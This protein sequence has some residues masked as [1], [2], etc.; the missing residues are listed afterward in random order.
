MSRVSIFVACLVLG[1]LA[2]SGVGQE[3]N[4]LPNGDFEK[5]SDGDGVPDG[6]VGNPHHFSRETLEGVHAYIKAFPSHAELLKGKE[7]RYSDSHLYIRREADKEWPDSVK[8]AS[9]YEGF[10]DPDN[11]LWASRLGS[12]PLPQGLE[13]GGVTLVGTLAPRVVSEPIAVKPNTGYRLSYWSRTCG[14]LSYAFQVLDAEANLSEEYPGSPAGAQMV[15]SLSLGWAYVPYWTRYE[16]PFR[17]GPEQKAIRIRPWLYI[18][19]ES[20]YH[21]IYFDDFRLVEDDSVVMGDISDP[22]N[23]EPVWPAEAVERG[24]AVAPRPTLPQTFDT[25][26]PLPEEIDQ[27]MVVT[28][29]PG[30]FASGV[31][32]LRALR[33]LGGPLVVG[34]KGDGCSHLNGWGFLS[35]YGDV[36]LRVC[37][38]LKVDKNGSQWEMRP[39]YL[40]PG[41]LLPEPEKISVTLRGARAVKVE[42]PKG[43]GRSVWVTAFVPA[44]APPGDYKGEIQVVASGSE[45]YA[46]PFTI[47]VRDLDLL[48]PDVDF[49]MYRSTYA[50]APDHVVVPG[51]PR[52]ALADN[53]RHGMTSVDQGGGPVWVYEDADGRT[54][55]NWS[56]FDV[57]M[58]QMVSAGFRKSFHYMPDGDAL[59]PD[60]QLAIL[61]RCREKGWPEPIFYVHDEPG[62]MGRALVDTMEKEFGAARRQGLRTVTSG[63]DWRTQGEA[64]DV[65]ILDVSQVG[66]EDWPEIQARAAELGAELQAYDCSG[67]L[68]THPRNVRFYTGLW[69]WA[70]GLKGNW[71]WEYAAGA[72]HAERMIASS[73]DS[74]PPEDWA[75]YGFA[76]SLPSGWGASTSWEARREGVDDYRYLRTLE[77][78]IERAV[79]VGKARGSVVV[80]AQKY[81]SDLRKRVPLDVFSY[82]KRPSTSLKQLHELAPEIGVEEYDRIQEDCATHITAIRSI[83]K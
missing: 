30:Q 79:K 17:T 27:P 48:E 38:P 75:P 45:G 67:D 13:L 23:P 83:L 19:D 76:F 24:F 20:E 28:A 49:G 14:S 54:R 73:S 80:A 78:E 42:V 61:E 47:R 65:W 68:A 69:T 41:P 53:R 63:L 51:A 10:V 59:R 55:I 62:A 34:P 70:A 2:V 11:L 21:R 1:L 16:I 35:W 72:S 32:F 40:M 12:G 3:I 64:Y 25:Y 82:S 81:L 22:V 57:V 31:L 5:D 58:E 18:L 77:I 8:E 52:A 9:F 26:Q 71:I 66:G 74:E 36:Q 60:V 4:L 15:T 56:A 50:Q 44:G 6:W 46:L 33:D 7:I 37:H 29:A 39:H 43:E